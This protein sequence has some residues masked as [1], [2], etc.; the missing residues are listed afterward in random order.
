MITKT[1]KGCIIELFKNH[2]FAGNVALAHGCNCQNS[3]E[4]GIARAI[5]KE[6]PQSV[7]ADKKTGKG[8]KRKLGTYSTWHAK[9]ASGLSLGLNLY[10]K[11]WCGADASLDAIREAFKTVNDGLYGVRYLLIPK[12]GCGIGGLK[13][14]DVEKVI[15]EATPD[16]EIIVG[17]L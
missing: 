15:N 7:V 4:A 2:R 14:A 12:I 11:Y 1:H 8:D 16:I 3:M 9:T 5:S 10:T 13:W 17:E 6:F